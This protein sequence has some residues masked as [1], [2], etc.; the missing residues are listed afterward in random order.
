M[1]PIRGVV[2]GQAS[3]IV[4]CFLAVEYLVSTRDENITK[5]ANYDYVPPN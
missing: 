2:F 4:I 3:F 5:L 1:H